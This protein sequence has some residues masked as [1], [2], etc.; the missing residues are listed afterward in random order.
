MDV[1][2][3]YLSSYW[4][5]QEHNNQKVL[6]LLIISYPNG[7]VGILKITAYRENHRVLD[8]QSL[9]NSSM[10][11]QIHTNLSMLHARVGFNNQSYCF[12]II[13]FL[14]TYCTTIFYSF[15]IAVKST[16]ALLPENSQNYRRADV[17][18]KISSLIK[19]SCPEFLK[20]VI[21]S[22]FYCWLLGAIGGL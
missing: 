22:L 9:V 21:I 19:I 14:G 2:S 18:L 1:T 4:L 13:S 20:M 10:V 3:F 12:F 5:K 17:N 16:N 7:S 6:L 8:F 11:Y 15:I